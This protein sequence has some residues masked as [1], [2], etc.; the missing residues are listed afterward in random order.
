M[1]RLTLKLSHT[2]QHVWVFNFT[3]IRERFKSYCTEIVGYSGGC[4]LMRYVQ[5]IILRRSDD[6][7]RLWLN[8]VKDW[9]H[10]YRFIFLFWVIPCYLLGETTDAHKHIHVYMYIS[11]KENDHNENIFTQNETE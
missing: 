11:H 2:R 5:I 7:F 3:K 1:R 10:I 6:S 8:S 4:C 9:I